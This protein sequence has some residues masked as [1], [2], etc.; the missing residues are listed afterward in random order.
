MFFG[1]PVG[2]VEAESA[3]YGK[4]RRGTEGINMADIT[5]DP[6]LFSAPFDFIFKVRHQP[7]FNNIVVNHCG[8][9]RKSFGDFL[10]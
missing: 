1:A 9:K 10:P 7:R 3:N 2:D 5:S 4:S 6:I 8:K